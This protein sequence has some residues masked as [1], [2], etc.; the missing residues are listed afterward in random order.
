MTKKWES[1]F[2]FLRNISTL[3]PLFCTLGR[4]D[5]A[6]KRVT[7]LS[8]NLSHWNILFIP[9]EASWY[10]IYQPA[11]YSQYPQYCW[12]PITNHIFFI[13][14]SWKIVLNNTM[15]LN[16]P[17]TASSVT[18]NSPYLN[19][20]TQTLAL[21]WMPIPH[22]KILTENEL[23]GWI[24]AWRRFSDLGGKLVLFVFTAFLDSLQWEE[25]IAQRKKKKACSG[26][27]FLP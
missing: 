22:M 6:F 11:W 23:W 27:P 10:I 1:T 17:W 26:V 21:H 18:L 19:Y 20:H 3:F 25:Y 24:K 13:S 2:N 5:H 9:Q 12:L 8:V 7:H 4:I 14:K 15:S 16:H